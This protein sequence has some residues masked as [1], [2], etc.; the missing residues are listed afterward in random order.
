MILGPQQETLCSQLLLV[1]VK[2]CGIAMGMRTITNLP[3]AFICL[4]HSFGAALIG[5]REGS[6]GTLQDAVVAEN[7]QKLQV[8]A[9]EILSLKARI[10]ALGSRMYSLERSHAVENQRLDEADKWHPD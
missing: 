6:I 8:E 5:E 7:K 3:V 2:L 4:Y 1:T 10:T 9:A